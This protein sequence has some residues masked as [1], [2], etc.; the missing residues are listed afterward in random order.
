MKF[1]KCH[2]C[3]VLCSI[4]FCTVFFQTCM[5]NNT[6]NTEKINDATPMTYNIE[7]STDQK[8]DNQTLMYLRENGWFQT[9]EAELLG[10]LHF[11]MSRTEIE[12]KLGSPVL[13]V[14]VQQAD[15][16]CLSFLFPKNKQEAC[17]TMGDLIALT[18][19]LDESDSLKEINFLS[20]T[21][22]TFYSKQKLDELL[23]KGDSMDLVRKKLGV[24]TSYEIKPGQKSTLVY[25]YRNT[26]YIGYVTIEFEQNKLVDYDLLELPASD[27]LSNSLI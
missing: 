16:Y 23:T 4:G 7:Y 8:I 15:V 18:L 13:V 25:A 5:G 27:P 20:F 26:D 6:L 1:K 19:H 24:P 22:I 12:Q 14:E 10:I 3:F 11:G 2:I 17:K 21:T 9:T